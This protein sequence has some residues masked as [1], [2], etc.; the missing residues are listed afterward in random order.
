MENTIA[1][2]FALEKSEGLNSTQ[3]AELTRLLEKQENRQTYAA[4]EKLWQAMPNEEAPDTDMAWQKLHA[5]IHAPRQSRLI[6]LYKNW[7][8]FAAAAVLVLVAFVF[9]LIPQQSESLAFKTGTAE[10]KKYE[11]PDGSIITLQP[12]SSIGYT[13]TGSNRQVQFEGDAYFEVAKDASHPFVIESAHCKTEVLGTAFHL[14]DIKSSEAALLQV[15]EGHVKFSAGKEQAEVLAGE[16]ASWTPAALRKEKATDTFNPETW[17]TGEL[18]FNNQTLALIITRL[19][20]QFNISVQTENSHILNCRFSGSFDKNISADD[21]LRI[22]AETTN[23][24][25]E[26]NGETRILKGEGCHE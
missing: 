8:M 22:L 25:F 18:T 3:Q 19:Q 17:K 21:C 4:L 5:A 13:K 24:R 26:K 1:E 16:Q 10:I 7:Y 9:L 2:L 15:T 20:S 6:P 11:L 23:L 14:L 12:N